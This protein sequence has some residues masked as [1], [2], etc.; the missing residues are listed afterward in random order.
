M[1]AFIILFSIA[2]GLMA[3]THKAVADYDYGKFEIEEVKNW[4]RDSFHFK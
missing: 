2:I 4:H 1:I 3:L